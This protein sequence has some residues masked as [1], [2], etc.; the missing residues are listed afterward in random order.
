MHTMCLLVFNFFLVVCAVPKM[1]ALTFKAQAYQARPWELTQVEIQD[2]I[3]QKEKLTYHY[4]GQ[5]LTRITGR[6]WLRD[7]VRF[8][9]DGYRR[10]RLTQPLRGGHLCGWS[11]AYAVW[12]E[13]IYQA[14]IFFRVDPCQPA[15]A[16]LLLLVGRLARLTRDEGVCY[17]V[18]TNHRA[19]IY[20][21]SFGL[22]SV[23]EA[24]LVLPMLLPHEEI[25]R[26]EQHLIGFQ[27]FSLVFG[28]LLVE[29]RLTYEYHLVSTPVVNFQGLRYACFQVSPLQ[30]FLTT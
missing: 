6:N 27:L 16:W 20:Q 8:S 1:G 3:D 29:P 12:F 4:R 18:D 22:Q 26:Q 2:Y 7:R 23:N 24:Y 19:T 14:R 5:T 28:Q 17:S 9:Y 25:D 30:K 13:L 11:T 21:G 10:Q 15:V